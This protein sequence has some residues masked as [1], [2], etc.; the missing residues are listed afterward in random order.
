MSKQLLIGQSNFNH[1]K[2]YSQTI[3]SELEGKNI[4]KK[5]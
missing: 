5:K 3:N 2:N 4:E 1:F